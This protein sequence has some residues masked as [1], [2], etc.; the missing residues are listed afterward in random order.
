MMQ[1]LLQKSQKVEMGAV[2]QHKTIHG[3]A[4]SKTLKRRTRERI[5]QMDIEDCL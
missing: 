3:K 5:K 1:H 4:K 2:F